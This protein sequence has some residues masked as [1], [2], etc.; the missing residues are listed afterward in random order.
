LRPLDFVEQSSNSPYV[1]T[2]RAHDVTAAGLGCP[3]G[4]VPPPPRIVFPAHRAADTA[5]GSL[6]ISAAWFSAVS[7]TMNAQTLRVRPARRQA[8][9]APAYHRAL[10]APRRVPATRVR[11][12]CSLSA[13]GVTT[14]STRQESVSYTRPP[15]PAVPNRPANRA[16][17][18]AAE[19]TSSSSAVAVASSTADPGHDLQRTDASAEARGRW[20]TRRPLASVS[21]A[22]C[23][24][25]RVVCL[26]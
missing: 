3:G 9:S 14:R 2:P 7:Q 26:R 1:V 11:S 12:P 10:S 16:L 5:E 17:A 18:A 13:A 21:A 25:P 19:L 8:G 23:R 4:A 20:R 24:E 22:D 6:V 15:R